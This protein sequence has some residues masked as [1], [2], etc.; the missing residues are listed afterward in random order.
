MFSERRKNVPLRMSRTR[1]R[2][3]RDDS[4]RILIHRRADPAF[5]T[6]LVLRRLQKDRSACQMQRVGALASLS[7]AVTLNVRIVRVIRHGRGRPTT[8]TTAVG[9]SSSLTSTEA[10]NP[11]DERGR[12]TDAYVRPPRFSAP[13]T[14]DAKKQARRDFTRQRRGKSRTHA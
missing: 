4:H 1:S 6:R 14:A 11:R 5:A 9:T 13:L 10:L 3:T 8:T 12:R 2:S 7:P